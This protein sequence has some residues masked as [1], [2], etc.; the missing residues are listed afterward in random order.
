[1]FTFLELMRDDWNAIGLGLNVLAD[2]IF[3]GSLYWAHVI[4]KNTIRKDG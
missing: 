1:M 2:A 4:A 3:F